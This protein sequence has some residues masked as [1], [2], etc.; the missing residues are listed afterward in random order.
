MRKV[1]D[2]ILK[3]SF[4]IIHFG[5]FLLCMVGVNRVSYGYK[6]DISENNIFIFPISLFLII[7]LFF[8][9]RKTLRLIE[10]NSK[11]FF[12]V[13]SVLLILQILLVEAYYFKTSWD[14]GTIVLASEHLATDEI[15]PDWSNDY[16]SRYPNNLFITILF[17]KIILLCKFIGA[18]Q[19]SYT[20]ILII[21]AAL[22]TL[23]GALLFLTLKKVLNKVA[24]A[25]LGYVF[26]ILLIWLSPWVSIPYSE[27]WGL[28]FPILI[29]YLYVNLDSYVYLKIIILAILT[30]IGYAIKPQVII[31]TIGIVA[32][33]IC[34]MKKEGV[35]T[36]IKSCVIFI[37]A[38][39]I[40]NIGVSSFKYSSSLK[41]DSEKEISYLHFVKMGLNNKSDGG[42]LASDVLDSKE[43]TTK[44]QRQQENL[45]VIKNRLK[46]YGVE[47]LFKHQVKKTLNNYNDGT[48]AWGLEGG[49]YYEIMETDSNFAKHIRE[50]YYSD[51]K[52][53]K[54]FKYITQGT[55]LVVLFLIIGNLFTK[56]DAL[57]KEK[58]VVY[59]SLMGLFLF[60]SIFESRSR[61]LYIYIPIFIMAAIFGLDSMLEKFRK[62]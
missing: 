51:G 46:D 50:F 59:L 42:Y 35:K 60:E 37:F 44:K 41:I 12:F 9:G 5:I 4:L 26:Y 13:S 62:K 17:S 14:V 8:I 53:H 6:L 29:L 57:T 55:W 47:G 38:F 25:W 40:C 10:S 43:A 34:Y 1:L 56:V 28:I 30:S 21:Q 54:Y 20:I 16:F 36:A 22:N 2:Y 31:M 7:L 19:S 23:T 3:Y 15:M 61:Y 32:V 39:V 11:I 24:F 49:F 27:S 33:T 58:K 52:Y 45:D 48:F 18:S